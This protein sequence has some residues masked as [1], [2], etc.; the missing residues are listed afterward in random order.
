MN[1]FNL[2]TQIRKRGIL[3]G[4]ISLAISAVLAGL[5]V[6]N[7]VEDAIQPLQIWLLF[8]IG[9]TIL[10]LISS[11]NVRQGR[12]WYGVDWWLAVISA[13]VITLFLVIAIIPEQFAPYD[14]EEEVGFGKLAP[15]QQSE[16]WL[17]NTS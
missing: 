11:P 1:N 3:L 17:C 5:I 14:Y 8:T 2:L 16:Y 10:L 13:I 4:G 15:G 6:V 7:D 12:I 9:A